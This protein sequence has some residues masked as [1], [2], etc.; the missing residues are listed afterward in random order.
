MNRARPKVLD[1]GD[2][3][4]S[5]WVG[6]FA[7]WTERHYLLMDVIA[8]IVLIALFDSATYGDLQMIGNAP[9]S[10]NRVPTIT[11]TIIMLSP[12][13]FR[14]RFPEGSAL[15]MAALV[16]AVQLLFLRSIL[17]IRCV[18]DGYPGVF[19]GIVWT[20]VRLA[21]GERGAGSRLVACG[22][23]GDGWCGTDTVSCS[24]C[25]CPRWQFH[26]LKME[27]G[28][29]RV[30]PGVGIDVGLVSPGDC[31]GSMEPFA[32]A[33]ALW[34]SLQREEALRAEQE[35]AEGAGGQ[36]RARPDQC[37]DANRST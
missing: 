7:Q 22:H 24:I 9:Y 5:N 37:G 16:S 33:Q 8:T 14:R 34:C 32:V 28:F 31:D 27:A 12:L 11:L 4:E 15:A 10:P 19:G 1:Q 26:A 25:S 18:R 36:L 35:L 3:R 23:Q 30:L 29:R 6:R 2:T 13:A 21:L 17:A 20:R